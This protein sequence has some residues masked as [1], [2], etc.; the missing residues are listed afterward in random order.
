M[1][2]ALLLRTGFGALFFALPLAAR[3]PEDPVEF[4]KIENP[5]RK[6]KIVL[7]DSDVVFT[8]EDLDQKFKDPRVLAIQ[9]DIEGR[10]LP[11]RRGQ[12]LEKFYKGNFVKAL[13]RSRDKRWLAV[14]SLKTSKKR[15]IPRSAVP[16]IDD[17][18]LEKKG[19]GG[20]GL[21]SDDE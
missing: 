10:S 17:K 6:Q 15:W 4:Y 7:R 12:V 21:N 3:P 8:S 9:F 2:L 16:A 14:E 5:T 13:F 19:S 20:S 1:R 18:I 11:G